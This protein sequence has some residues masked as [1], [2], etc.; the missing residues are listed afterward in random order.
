MAG[1][2]VWRLAMY[3]LGL[4]DAID[5]VMTGPAGDFIW[6]VYTT[7]TVDGAAPTRNQTWWDDR[8]TE[9]EERLVCGVYKMYI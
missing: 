6:P 2:I 1:G 3:H 4:D 7:N 8:L 5:T 9:E